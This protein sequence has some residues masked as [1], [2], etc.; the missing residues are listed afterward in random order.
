MK[1]KIYPLIFIPGSRVGQGKSISVNSGGPR[2]PSLFVA[3]TEAQRVEKIFFGDREPPVISGSGWGG[4]GGVP[5]P[6]PPL[7]PI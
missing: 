7:P 5:P 6:P 2:P 3:Q 4:G 1:K